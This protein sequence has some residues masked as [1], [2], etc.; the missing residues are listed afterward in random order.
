MCDTEMR[1]SGSIHQFLGHILY[2][3]FVN[4][5]YFFPP[6]FVFSFKKRNLNKE[7]FKRMFIFLFCERHCVY[8]SKNM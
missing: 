2:V 3:Q 1:M 7:F 4:K 5:R 6:N 8:M